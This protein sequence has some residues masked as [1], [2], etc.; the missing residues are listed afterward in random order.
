M[1]AAAAQLLLERIDGRVS[2][3]HRMFTPSLVVRRSSA[4]LDA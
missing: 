2:P 3:V 1:G 4:P